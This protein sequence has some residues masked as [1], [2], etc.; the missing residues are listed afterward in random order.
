VLELQSHLPID[1]SNGDGPIK[2]TQSVLCVGERTDQ[3]AKKLTNWLLAFRAN[4]LDDRPFF[5]GENAAIDAMQSI[6]LIVEIMSVKIVLIGFLKRGKKMIELIKDKMQ[7]E[8]DS[9]TLSDSCSDSGSGVRATRDVF[10][11]K[12]ST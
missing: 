3:K 1:K 6:A 9:G 2:I 8:S 11:Y 5:N 7:S 4:E 10:A 12:Y